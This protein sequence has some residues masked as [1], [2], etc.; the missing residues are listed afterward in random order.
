MG[1]PQSASEGSD[2]TVTIYGGIKIGPQATYSIDCQGEAHLH[3]VA[4]RTSIAIKTAVFTVES[5]EIY[6]TISG[7][8][9]KLTKTA[10]S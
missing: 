4:V 9:Y 10:V 3:S 7:T 1:N 2:N 6:V 8:K 5:N